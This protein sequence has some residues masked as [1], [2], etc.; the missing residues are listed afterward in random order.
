VRA[1]FFFTA[2]LIT[3]LLGGFSAFGGK[4]R[5]ENS[6]ES[7]KSLRHKSQDER[8]AIEKAVKWL[9][10]KQMANQRSGTA[11][12]KIVPIQDVGISVQVVK[13]HQ[14]NPS[15]I[16]LSA[17]LKT[18]E[19]LLFNDRPR[20]DSLLRTLFRVIISPNAP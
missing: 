5:T 17:S 19:S 14:T 9:L 7:H 18:A 1:K 10:L 11:D 15:L 16:T 3:A 4:I 13:S 6:S 20:Q 12:T 2:I 8:Y